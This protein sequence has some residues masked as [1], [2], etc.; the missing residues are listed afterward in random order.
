MNKL[1]KLDKILGTKSEVKEK[2]SL[3]LLSDILNKLEKSNDFNDV[4]SKEL[5]EVF[6]RIRKNTATSNGKE[7][8]LISAVQ[9]LNELLNKNLLETNNVKLDALL[10]ELINVCDREFPTEINV[11]NQKEFPTEIKVSNPVTEIKVTNIKDARD[12][13]V[14]ITNFPEQKEFPKK[15]TVDNFPEQKE[16]PTEIKVSNQVNEVKVK[17]PIW[18]KQFT[19]TQLTATLTELITSAVNTIK[20]STF[21]INASRHE[22]PDKALA[23]KLIDK[24][25]KV[26]KDLFP[27]INLPGGSGG[28]NSVSQLLNSDKAIINPATEDKQNDIIDG[29]NALDINT[30]ELES[31][32]DVHEELLRDILR[33]LKHL[34][35]QV[36]FMTD[37]TLSDE[38]KIDN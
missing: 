36:S 33:E 12:R 20:D 31:G 10:K 37:T 30:D 3:R 17:K 34:N 23:V 18:Y 26:I 25:G 21:K 4:N 11:S 9:E 38:D 6:D 35:L 29:I 8:E 5:S 24:D 1:K 14:E 16:F 13:K 27:R 15:I 28:G 7:K 32:Q 19:L 2:K 22:N